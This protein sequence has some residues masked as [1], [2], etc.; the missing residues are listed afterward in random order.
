MVLAMTALAEFESSVIIPS[1]YTNNAEISV[2]I[3]YILPA[4]TPT[5][6]LTITVPTDLDISNA[7]CN[8]SCSIIPPKVLIPFTNADSSSTHSISISLSGVVNAPSYKPISDFTFSLKS[9]SNYN[10][11]SDTV[12]AWTNTALSSFTT[13]VTSTDGFLA[14]NVVFTF[15]LDGLSGKQKYANIKI[16]NLFEALT[17]PP[18]GATLVSSYEV[19]FDITGESSV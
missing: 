18:T 14:E 7:A 6:T 1:S 2:K 17:S 9:S 12:A 13:T 15:N 10:S 11:I 19:Q 4:R 16:N 3:D 5:G 8:V